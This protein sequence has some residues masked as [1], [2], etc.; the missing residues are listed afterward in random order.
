L[1]PYN[2]LRYNVLL[3]SKVEYTFFSWVVALWQRVRKDRPKK[4]EKRGKYCRVTNIVPTLKELRR[5]GKRGKKVS[6]ALKY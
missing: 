2:P 6:P 3:Y 5:E 1:K 4:R